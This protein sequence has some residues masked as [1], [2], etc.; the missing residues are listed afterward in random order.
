MERN[1][2]LPVTIGLMVAVGGWIH[3]SLRNAEPQPP[4]DPT[5]PDFIIRDARLTKMDRR[6][7]VTRILEATE[8]R[9]FS[10]R[11]LTEAD[12]PVLTLFKPGEQWRIASATARVLHPD[13][14]VLLDGD[15][16][17]LRPETKDAAALHVITRDVRFLQDDNYAETAE[18]AVIESPGHRVEGIGLQAWLND[19]VRVKLLDEVHGIHEIN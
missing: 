11:E 14:E 2:T 12:A 4:S 18:P 13:H 19:P 17:I 3:L 7:N 1:W 15:V 10:P 16:D 9:H 8:L 6:G 5:R